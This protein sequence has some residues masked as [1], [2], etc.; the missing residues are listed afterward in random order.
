MC[1]TSTEHLSS[2]LDEFMWR[3]FHGKK[4]VEACDNL[5][6]QIFYFYL[7]YC[8]P[9]QFQFHKKSSVLFRTSIISEKGKSVLI[10]CILK[11]LLRT[12]NRTFV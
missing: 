7:V 4:T 9:K 2:Y 10:H 3:Q 6:Q 11:V 1:G 12:A 5:L 8:N